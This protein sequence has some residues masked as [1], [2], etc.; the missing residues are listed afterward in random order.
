MP[1]FLNL[2]TRWFVSTEHDTLNLLLHSQERMRAILDRERMKCD[3]GSSSFALL[4]LTLSP[5]VDSAVLVTLARILHD[6][7]RVTDD[8]GFME[9]HCV[10]VML[11]ETPAEGAWKLSEDVCEMLAVD[12]PRPQCAVYVYPSSPGDARKNS[13]G[14]VE[15]PK[16]RESSPTNG[17]RETRRRVRP[18]GTLFVQKLPLWKRAIDVA[19]AGSALLLGAPL[20]ALVAA[21]IKLTSSGPVFFA[22]Q[23]DGLG[24]RKFLM[25]KFRSMISDA[26]VQK[27]SLREISEQDGPAFKLRQD[28][29][30]TRLG[31][32][33]RATSI[34]E[35]PQLY[36]V[37]LGDMTLVGPRPLPCDESRRCELWQRRRLDVT[38]G[39]TC[40][41]QV[42]GRSTVSFAE[43]MRM[44]LG[45]IRHISPLTDLKLIAQT[46]VTVLRRRGAY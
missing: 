20:F 18:M 17:H 42:R 24:G 41:W 21:A 16:H 11:P 4:T 5:R 30:V 45:Y 40:I 3:R 19:A 39:L 23:R 22:Q 25:Y 35:L 46:V 34:D 43:W 26:E 37:L 1:R 32:L 31:R 14:H 36:N 38:P 10:G 33:L 15:L 9:G 44:D 6:R 12:F 28:P 7:I 2:V 8:A 13:N 27:A 29:R